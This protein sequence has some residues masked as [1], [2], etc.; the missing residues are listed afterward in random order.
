MTR[1]PTRPLAVSVLLVVPLVVFRSVVYLNDT[2]TRF[3][4]LVHL[5]EGNQDS[6]SAVAN[7]SNPARCG[8]LRQMDSTCSWDAGSLVSKSLLSAG[9]D[10]RASEGTI[11]VSAL[12]GALFIR[13]NMGNQFQAI[14]HNATGVWSYGVWQSLG[15]GHIVRRRVGLTRFVAFIRTRT[16]E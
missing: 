3:P 15:V 16:G 5:A 11:L 8:T 12:P 7:S 10:S 1:R 9:S 4:D 6:R 14:D 2:T 13:R